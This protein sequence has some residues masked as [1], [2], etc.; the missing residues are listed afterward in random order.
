MEIGHEK[1]HI[2]HS[3]FALLIF[4]FVV[5]SVFL[6][7]QNA[8]LRSRVSDGG[9]SAITPD[10]K[11]EILIFTR[12]FIESVLKS[13]DPVD[14]ETRLRLENAVRK[15]GDSDILAA[16]KAFVESPDEFSAQERVVDLLNVLVSKTTETTE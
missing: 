16:W 2:P 3:I 11:S 15:I 5:L 7:F 14:F 12:D 1:H 6:M 4:V 9:G 13:D 8:E 10:K